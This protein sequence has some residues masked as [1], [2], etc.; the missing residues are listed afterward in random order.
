MV[1]PAEEM[2]EAARVLR[3]RAG[4]ASFGPWEVGPSFGARDSRVYVR[5]EGGFDW[6]GSTDDPRPVITGQVANVA[7]FRANATHIAALHPLV[8]FAL[9]EWLEETAADMEHAG[10]V[11][12]RAEGLDGQPL[13]VWVP[14]DL[15]HHPAWTAALRLARTYLGRTT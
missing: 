14:G 10:A 12:S 1:S 6:V 3:E 7:E 9:A 8:A 5:P 13:V 4:A 2:R 11:E 15:G